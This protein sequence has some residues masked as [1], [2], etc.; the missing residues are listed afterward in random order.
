MNKALYAGTSLLPAQHA[1]R[2]DEQ[3]NIHQ[4]RETLHGAGDGA[5]PVPAIRVGNHLRDTADPHRE[6]E[7]PPLR[8]YEG[9]VEKGAASLLHLHEHADVDATARHISKAGTP[10]RIDEGARP[11]TTSAD[12][13]R[14][15]S[16]LRLPA[17]L[18]SSRGEGKYT[19]DLLR[20]LS[21]QMSGRSSESFGYQAQRDD[22]T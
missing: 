4:L 21:E 18:R 22:G 8:S 6:V 19:E 16:Q 10:A 1:Q 7:L 15:S 9:D 20:L 13:Y 5:G 14:V 11:A 3:R 12:Y 2:S 17:H